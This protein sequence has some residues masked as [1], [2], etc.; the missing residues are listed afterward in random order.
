[1]AHELGHR[2]GI[3]LKFRNPLDGTIVDLT[4]GD[5]HWSEFLN[6]RSMIS[7]W[8]MFSDQPYSEKSQ[9]EGYVYEELP[10]GTF[11]RHLPPWNIA[12]G[13][14]ALDLYVMGLIGP[15]DVP[16][17]FLISDPQGTSEHFQAKKVPVRIQDIIAACGERVPGVQ[18]SQKEFTIGIYLLHEG[19]RPPYQEKLHQAQG[20]EKSLI[21]YFHAATRRPDV[22][23]GCTA[24][25]AERHAKCSM[26]CG[27]GHSLAL[28]RSCRRFICFRQVVGRR[29][30]AW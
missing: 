18:E 21:E 19:N 7:V 23:R 2:W 28:S 6:T 20:I 15:G 10:D 8:R 25:E 29:Q 3:A 22:S 9:M 16:D 24:Q 14:S 11:R 4:G 12:S 17:T 1:M 5:G 27:L 30:Q 26:K 13:F